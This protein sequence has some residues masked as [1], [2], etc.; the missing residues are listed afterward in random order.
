VNGGAYRL[1]GWKKVSKRATRLRKKEE[2]GEKKVRPLSRAEG[3][4]NQAIFWHIRGLCLKGKK[5]KETAKSGVKKSRGLGWL[6]FP[7]L[8]LAMSLRI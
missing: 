5:G 2:N 6:L 7:S 4:K 8:T 3:L 1:G